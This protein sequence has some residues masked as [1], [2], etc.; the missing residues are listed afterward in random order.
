MNWL[1]AFIYRHVAP[2]IA[3]AHLAFIGIAIATAA[4]WTP[5]WPL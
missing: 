5:P 2:A 3:G 4:H 1:S